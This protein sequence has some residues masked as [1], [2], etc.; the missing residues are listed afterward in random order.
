MASW[1]GGR[2]WELGINLYIDTS[3]YKIDNQ[4]GTATN[5][6]ATLLEIL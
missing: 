1:D 4:E 6:Q 2:N 3:M 5:P